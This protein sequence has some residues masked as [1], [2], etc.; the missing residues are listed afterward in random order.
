MPVTFDIQRKNVYVRVSGDLTQAERIEAS[1]KLLRL[2][3]LGYRFPQNPL[4]RRGKKRFRDKRRYDVERELENPELLGLEVLNEAQFAMLGPDRFVECL[5][6][7]EKLNWW[8]SEF[9]VELIDRRPFE[10]PTGIGGRVRSFLVAQHVRCLA[11]WSQSML[12]KH[13]GECPG[14][15]KEPGKYG[16]PWAV[17][18]IK[19]LLAFG[20]PRYPFLPPRRRPRSNFGSVA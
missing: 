11:I 8:H 7:F 16:V 10:L 2:L 20:D 18:T 5:P 15:L 13:A 9:V 17:D 12:E 19:F 4:L 14:L 1:N 6:D 3:A